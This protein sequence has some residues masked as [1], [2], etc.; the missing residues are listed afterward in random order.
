ML[1]AFC[2]GVTV[3][4]SADAETQFRN[5]FVDAFKHL[6]DV[7]H[8]DFPMTV[9]YAFKQQEDNIADNDTQ[10]SSTG[11]DTMLSALIGTGFQI[12]GT[13]PVR[14]T[15]KARTVA[16]GTNALASAIVLACRPRDLNA[17]VLTRA[18][19]SRT[20][21]SELPNAV[22]LLQHGNIAPV[23]LAQA[24]IGPGMAVFSRFS[25]NLSHNGT[26]PA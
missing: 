5:G 15:K 12:T 8:P 9:Y 23:D 11:W 21:K 2:Y 19:F 18:Q 6:R 16:H 22:R 10:R 25:K 1:H 14:A 4:S 7:S 24:S 17:P 20:L 13:M 26:N 3:L